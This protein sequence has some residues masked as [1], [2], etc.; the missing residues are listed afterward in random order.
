MKR[1]LF[2][3]LLVSVS[4]SVSAQVDSG[5]DGIGV[6]FDSGAT[7]VQAMVEEETQSITAYLVLTRPTLQG[8]LY[9]WEAHLNTG[10]GNGYTGVPISG[11]PVNAGNI[12]TNMPMQD[13]FSFVSYAYEN[14]PYQI[15]ST[16]MVLAELE[17]FGPFYYPVSICVTEGALYAVSGEN[18]LVMNPSSGNWDS[19]MA[20]INGPAP[21]ASEAVSWGGVKGLFR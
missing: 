17:F 16:A 6:Y 21:V 12:V 3:S 9:Y 4:A 8:D 1:L 13:H 14:P 2:V 19:P 5:P 7:I 11:T 10:C 18:W 20:V 15:S